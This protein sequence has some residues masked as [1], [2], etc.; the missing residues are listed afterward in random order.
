MHNF[1][2]VNRFDSVIY[3]TILIIRS[4]F[5]WGPTIRQEN[6]NVIYVVILELRR[7]D[8]YTGDAKY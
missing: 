8:L 7:N 2:I 5:K 3:G 4:K 1:D 6:D